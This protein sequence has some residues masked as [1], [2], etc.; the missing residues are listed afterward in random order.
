MHCPNVAPRTATPVETIAT[1]VMPGMA[2]T[3]AR[4]DTD[5]GVPLI[6]GAR[7]TMVGSALG[8][9]EI[10]GELLAA[11]DRGQRVDT[12]LRPCR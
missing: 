9:V 4:F 12:V 3:A 6:V 5:F 10:H 2:L 11:G 1:S 8:T 7:R